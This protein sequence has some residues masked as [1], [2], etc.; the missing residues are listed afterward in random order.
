MMLW[1]AFQPYG[2]M[3]DAYVARKKDSRGNHFGFIRYEGVRDVMATLRGMNTVTIFEAKVSVSVAKFDKNHRAFQRISYGDTAGKQHRPLPPREN[4]ATIKKPIY[5]YMP[6]KNGRSYSEVVKGNEVTK[7]GEVKTVI[8]EER[9]AIYPDHCMMRA[10]IIELKNV[11]ALKEI[12]RMLDDG[13][14]SMYPVSY[15]GGLKCMVVFKTK[16]E[17]VEFLDNSGYGRDQLVESASLWTGQDMQYDRLIWLRITGIPIHLR[18]SKLYDMVGGCFGR[19]VG[20]S[21]FS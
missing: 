21:D 2:V 14:Y 19:V 3:K 13:G 20:E 5:E 8:A 18:D 15:L 17:A 10:V 16:R 9:I 7:K 11:L 12:R 4:P 1:R 6:V